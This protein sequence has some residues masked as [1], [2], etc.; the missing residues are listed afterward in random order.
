M[1]SVIEL[2]NARDARN[3]VHRAIASV[4]LLVLSSDSQKSAL[5][6]HNGRFVALEQQLVSAR[7]VLNNIITKELE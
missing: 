2:A 5:H 1:L 6:K 4:S 7:D 3:D